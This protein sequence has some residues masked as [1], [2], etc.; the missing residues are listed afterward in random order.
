M[1]LQ[2]DAVTIIFLCRR[3]FPRQ[4]G[5]FFYHSDWLFCDNFFFSFWVRLN[6]FWGKIFLRSSAAYLMWWFF[7]FLI[8][9]SF[10][11]LSKI[12]MVYICILEFKSFFVHVCHFLKPNRVCLTLFY[13]WV[14]F[15]HSFSVKDKTSW[16]FDV[17]YKCSSYFDFP[18]FFNNAVASFGECF[19]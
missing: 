4:L 16:S 1:R 7:F 10:S 13:A 14:S 9:V 18:F 17:L 15:S 8:T 5:S 6:K 3:R 19:Y 12:S 11:R 2:L